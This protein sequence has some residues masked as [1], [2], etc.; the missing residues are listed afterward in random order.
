MFPRINIILTGNDAFLEVRKLMIRD[1][2]WL[3]LTKGKEINIFIPFA[4]AFC[5][6]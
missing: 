3:N 1:P 5:C 4:A 2:S 6:N